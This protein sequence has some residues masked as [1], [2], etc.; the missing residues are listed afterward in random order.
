MFVFRINNIDLA[1]QKANEN[2]ELER[3]WHSHWALTGRKAFEVET[4][5]ITS[6]YVIW[7]TDMSN[8]P[9][10]LLFPLFMATYIYMYIY[11]IIYP[12]GVPVLMTPIDS[13]L[14]SHD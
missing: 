5:E 12:L 7:I 14:D 6:I 11:I 8:N 2:T 3:N 1:I 10:K 4:V 13:P 9:T